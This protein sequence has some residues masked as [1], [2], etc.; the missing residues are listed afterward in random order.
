MRNTE[1][2]TIYRRFA[3]LAFCILALLSASRLL[4]VSF[5]MDRVSATGGFVTV[6]LQ[7]IRFDIILLGMIFGPAL[8]IKT[9]AHLTPLAGFVRRWVIPVY[10]GVFLAFV[11]FLEGATASFIAEFDSRPNYLFVEY[12]VYPREVIPTVIGE[13]PIEL[14]VCTILA[15]AIAGLVI[16]WLRADP[17][18]DTVVSVLFCVLATPVVALV[19]LAM[20]RSTLDH[21]PVNPSVAAFSQDSMVNQLPLNSAY[22]V[23]YAIYERKRDA[24]GEGVL[25]GK[26]D[27]EQ[28]LDM[29]LAE[30]GISPSGQRDSKAPT[31]HHQVATRGREQPLNLVIVLQESLGA[32]Y[33]GSL[34]GKDLTPELDE[35]ATQ[36]ISFERLYATGIRSARGV[37]AIITGFTPTAQL[38]VIKRADTQ[39]NFFTLA[40]LLERNGYQTSF[41]YGGESHFD[42]MRRFFLNNGFQSIIDKKDYEN[43][44]FTGSW[45]VSDEDLFDRAHDVLN[46]V[47]DQP[48]FSLIFTSS[49]HSPYEIPDGRVSENAYGPREAAINYADYALGR[50]F[51]EARQSDYWENTVFLVVAD[52]GVRVLGGK[53]VPV[54]RFR[55]PGVIVGATIE[56]RIIPGIASQ[57]DL[58]PTLLSLIGL[59]S[60]HPGIGRDLTLPEHAEGS[61]RAMMQFG[62]LQAYMEDDRVVVLRPDLPP[63]TFLKDSTGTMELMP[64]G[65]PE[66][67]R[68]ALAHA[69]WGPMTIRNRAYFNYRDGR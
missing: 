62:K 65:D 66:L 58:F 41:L 40:S 63:T 14:L 56:P 29:V 35:L 60:D 20:V 68:K 24:A 47:G 21:R 26:M 3:I 25:Y 52:H 59:S 49:N 8:L 51:D 30:A 43:P 1:F 39:D 31:L 4:L 67:E 46:S 16:R 6:L 19:T 18:R 42:N 69:R 61:G 32:D 15:I 28:V 10:F 48:F 34:G 38:S 9:W 37:E 22:S 11:F 23:I 7:G 44:T 17:Q 45:G 54:E 2:I 36:G 64:E 50:F 13:R 5:H 55:I 27:D 57:I 33:V 12:L 53:L